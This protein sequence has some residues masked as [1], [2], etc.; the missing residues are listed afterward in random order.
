MARKE[1]EKAGEGG[2]AAVLERP[3][4]SRKHQQYSETVV[5]ALREQFG[6]TSVMAV[7]RLDKIVV[8]MGVGKGDEDPKL[9]ENAVR[10]LATI[11]G[12][13][14][15]ITRAKKAV[16]NFK[17]REGYKIG[18]KVTL[19]GERMYHFF[20]K[21]VSVVL[22]RLRD[23]RGLSPNS[24]DGRGNF[25]L[26]LKEQIVFPEISYDTFDKIRGMDV[27][28]CT[29]ARTDEEAREFLKK[30]GMPIRT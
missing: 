17:I 7:P 22:P 30:M 15:V 4:I 27:I 5:P 26:G 9:L 12:Q 14:P 18:C 10:D 13:R 19:R 3:P 28:V 1:K 8:N 11:T 2:G 29:T 20:D 25:A 21:I 6:Y 23:F 24:F 16:S